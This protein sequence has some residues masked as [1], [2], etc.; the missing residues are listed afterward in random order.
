MRAPTAPQPRLVRDASRNYGACEWPGGCEERG[1]V[2]Y[3]R[4][5][6]RLYCAPHAK[7][8]SGRLRAVLSIEDYT[9]AAVEP[10]RL[11]P[12]TKEC[13][14]CYALNFAEEAVGDGS[15]MHFNICCSNGR[16][17]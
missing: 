8:V 7:S 14:R 17:A 1:R 2:R 5:N 4:R 6:G 16:L 9:D 13:G 15:A 11:G 10:H 12:M 3:P